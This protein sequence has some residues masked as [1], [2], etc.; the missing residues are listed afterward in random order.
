MNVKEFGQGFALLLKTLVGQNKYVPP[1]PTPTKAQ[2]P[3]PTPTPDYEK[4]I[5]GFMTDYGAPAAT[6]SADF[7][8]EGQKYPI[9][10][11]YPYLVPSLSINETSGGKN[12]TFPNNITNWGIKE[13][14]FQPTSPQ[15][16]IERTTS[17]IGKR[18]PFYEDFRNTGNLEDFAAHYAPPGENNTKKYVENLK[19]LMEQMKKYERR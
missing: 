5:K 6:L 2:P 3:S 19:S 8:K 7:V 4:A 16:V 1:S 11:K 15:Q 12:V 17:G 18:A 14:S 9:T 13:P 10:R